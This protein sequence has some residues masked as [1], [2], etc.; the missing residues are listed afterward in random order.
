MT[1]F[2]S[3]FLTEIVRSP[4]EKDSQ[5][6]ARSLRQYY[7]DILLITTEALAANRRRQIHLSKH[8]LQISCP[9]LAYTHNSR[10]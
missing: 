3:V 5:S 2:C 4:W 7:G 8:W 9:G 1:T 10:T 6:F